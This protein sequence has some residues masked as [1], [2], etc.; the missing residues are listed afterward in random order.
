VLQHLLNEA[1]KSPGISI[2][3]D[4]EKETANPLI[5]STAQR[6]GAKLKTRP[7]LIVTEA[8][9]SADVETPLRKG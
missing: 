8:V 7:R 9:T 2:S 4:E 5:E 1:E 6:T 3:E